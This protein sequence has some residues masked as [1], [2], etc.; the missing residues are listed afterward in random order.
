MARRSMLSSCPT[1]CSTSNSTAMLGTSNSCGTTAT[2]APALRR[3]TTA[4]PTCKTYAGSSRAVIL[5]TLRWPGS[6]IQSE[7][8]RVAVRRPNLTPEQREA[9]GTFRADVEDATP[10][11]NKAFPSLC[12]V[13]QQNPKELGTRG[14]LYCVAANSYVRC[15]IKGT[16]VEHH[17][18][19]LGVGSSIGA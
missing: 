12:I 10:V 1:S 13:R 5:R 2:L 15:S 14:Q 9:G 16:Y 17:I 3:D 19:G 11:S 6:N 18:S 7:R 8:G 4:S